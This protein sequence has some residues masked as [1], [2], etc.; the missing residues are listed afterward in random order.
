MV[1]KSGSIPSERVLHLIDA[2]LDLQQAEEYTRALEILRQAQAQAPDYAPIHLLMGLAYRDSGKF[3]EAEAS[4]RQV[5]QLEPEQPEAIQSLGLILATQGRSR[6]A[7]EFLKIHAELQPDDA[8]TLKALGAELA[9]LGRREEGVRLLE[10]AWRATQN[11]EVGITYGRYLIRIRRWE[12]AEEILHQVANSAP[13]PHPLVEWAYA[14][15]LLEHYEGALKV[16]QRILDMDPSFDR[17]WRGVSTCY[18]N[19]GRFSEA[20]EAAEHALAIDDQHC[21]NWLAKANA[22]M[23]LERP[24]EVLEA[25]RT[26]TECVS[27]DDPEA[28]P[29]L[30]ELRLREIE[31]LFQLGRVDEA[32]VRLEEL[33]H[34]F[35]AEER[36]VHIHFSVLN[37]LGRWEDALRVLDEAQDAGLPAYGSLAPL[38]YELLHLLGRPNE[39]W[40][41]I[42]PMIISQK[43]RV[44]VLGDIGLSLYTRG[45]IE[46]ARAVFE[47]LYTFASDVARFACNLGFILVGEGNLSEAEASFLNAL[48][49]PDNK[50]V[51]PLV[52]ANLGYLHLIWGNYVQAEVSLQQAVSLAGEEEAILRVAYWQDD[53]VVPDYSAYPAR[54]LPV[55]AAANANL[56]T[57]AL[58]RGQAEDAESLA[59]SMMQET[60]N[61]PW[62]YEMLGWVLRAGSRLDEARQAWTSALRFTSDPQEKGAI[63]RWLESLF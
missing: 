12:Q 37:S 63:E 35:P 1:A 44:H 52:L 49:A 59:R 38:R 3:E 17:A 18:A 45:K 19:L 46:A 6:E 40:D 32:L 28:Q 22:L 50:E 20:L 57:L 56:V 27:L 24:A 53:E 11:T 8:V 5:I 30:G 7:I 36:F 23:G 2:A 15:V 41:F 26:G 16:L 62:G 34:Q 55:R 51:R 25:A 58:A 60:P 61:M 33:R 13:Q 48:E 10:Q 39:A 42:Q 29:V 54:S 31:A 14:L 43:E 47:Q 21:R 9:H 4:L